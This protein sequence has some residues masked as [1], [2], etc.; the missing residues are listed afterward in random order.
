M[1]LEAW[2]EAEPVLRESLTLREELSPGTRATFNARSMLGEALLGQQRYTEA[3][4]LLLD[5]YAG[6]I[7]QVDSNPYEFDSR[8]RLA[9]E[10]LI[11]L[12]E[13]TENAEE[14]EKWQAEWEAL[15][16]LGRP[17]EAWRG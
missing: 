7:Q 9:V 1:K 15:G 6:L 4:P 14:A 16:C 2:Q 11:R 17:W 12:Y 13:A 8:V 3:E 10:R 5:G